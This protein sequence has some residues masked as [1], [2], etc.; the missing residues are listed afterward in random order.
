LSVFWASRGALDLH[1]ATGDA[2]YLGLARRCF[3]PLRLLQQVFDN[4][5][6]SIDTFGGFASMNAD[7][8][9]ND[10]RQGLFAPLFF[11]FY[12]ATGEPEFFERGVATLKACFTT[13]LIEANSKI[14][15][16]NLVHFRPIDRGAILENYGHTGRDEVTS[17]YLSPDWGCGTSLYAVGLSLADHGQVYVDAPRGRAWGLDRCLAHFVSAA[18]GEVAIEVDPCDHQRL[19]IVVSAPTQRLLVNGRPAEAVAAD[20]RR[21]VARFA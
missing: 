17:G 12:R 3:A 21:F 5:R 14:A 6:L 18:D 11:D 2:A 16:G 19:E 13:M 20:A 8:E 10:A 7:A 15:P 9:F 1:L 4:P